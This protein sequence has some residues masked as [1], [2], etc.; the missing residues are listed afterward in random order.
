MK[1]GIILLVERR[2]KAVI[3]KTQ[4]GGRGSGRKRDMKKQKKR[5][6]NMKTKE[7]KRGLYESKKNSKNIF[8]TLYLI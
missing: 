2:G 8:Y 7:M 4:I 6:K 1:T 5:I 3:W